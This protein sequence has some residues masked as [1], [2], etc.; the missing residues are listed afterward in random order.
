MRGNF[1]RQ[2]YTFDPLPRGNTVLQ[3]SQ[4]HNFT[5]INVSWNP[6]EGLKNEEYKQDA[7]KGVSVGCTNS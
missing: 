2:N 4:M 3:K 6:W 7:Y 5:K 1:V